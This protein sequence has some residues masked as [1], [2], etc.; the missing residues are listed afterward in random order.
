M[1]FRDKEKKLLADTFIKTGE[2]VLSIV[3]FGSIVSGKFNILLFLGG[4]CIFIA[5]LVMAI[6][7]SSLT[8]NNGREAKNE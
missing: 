4:I 6:Y 1:R 5:L 8:D 2:Y 7:I 3:V